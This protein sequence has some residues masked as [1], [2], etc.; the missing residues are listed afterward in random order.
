MTLPTRP[1]MSMAGNEKYGR[2]EVDGVEITYLY[3]LVALSTTLGP[4]EM[5]I[6]R[7]F[8]C[9]TRCDHKMLRVD[10]RA[11]VAE[12]AVLVS[13]IYVSRASFLPNFLTS[14]ERKL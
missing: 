3:N 13:I 2:Y 5:A 12:I 1:S 11:G 7:G 14:I 10:G 9:H 8:I 6:L 4:W